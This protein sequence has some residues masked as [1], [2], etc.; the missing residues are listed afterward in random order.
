M[1]I[2]L[3]HSTFGSL[4]LK[5]SFRPIVMTKD[6]FLTS[7]TSTLLTSHLNHRLQYS[8]LSF[9]YSFHET[10]ELTLVF[11]YSCPLN[12][13]DEKFS[14]TT[15]FFLLSVPSLNYFVAVMLIRE[16]PSHF[17]MYKDLPVLSG[18]PLSL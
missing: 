1:N 8:L 4:Y 13:L 2:F 12:I 9:S 11:H 10:S 17:T 7:Y 15:N 6:V 18:C 3:S 16:D 14:S 5:S